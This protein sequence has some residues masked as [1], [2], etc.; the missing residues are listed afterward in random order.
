MQFTYGI[1]QCDVC[2]DVI[3][4]ISCVCVYFYLSNHNCFDIQYDMICH[5][6]FANF[7]TIIE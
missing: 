6:V 4:S 2:L 5:T 3:G 1:C 7:R